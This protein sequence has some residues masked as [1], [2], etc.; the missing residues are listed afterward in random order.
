VAEADDRGPGS[1]SSTGARTWS[2]AAGGGS[3]R[4]GPPVRAGSSSRSTS[5]ISRRSRSHPNPA[6]RPRR[7]RVVD[8]RSRSCIRSERY[9]SSTAWTSSRLV[10]ASA[11]TVAA[12]S[13][14][15]RSSVGGVAVAA[16][17]RRG[18]AR[19]PRRRSGRR[20]ARRLDGPRTVT[21]RAR[22]RGRRARGPRGGRARPPSRSS[23]AARAPRAVEVDDRAGRRAAGEV[24][25][26]LGRP[27]AVEHQLEEGAVDPLGAGQLL[28]LLVEDAG[29]HLVEDLV[30][31]DVVGQLHDREAARVGD[32]EHPRR[33]LV[34]VAPELDAEPGEPASSRSATR[35]GVARAVPQRVGGGEQELVP[36]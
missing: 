25:G 12:F 11:A 23:R 36:A 35:P 14:A 10:S 3:P 16:A 26:D 15:T 30:E 28:R 17:R 27:V 29:Q 18:R 19:A 5:T 1:R 4:R 8:P 20:R 24:A 33:E 2:P 13:S 34:E 7:R 22:R 6:A 9:L 21:R 32:L 31:A